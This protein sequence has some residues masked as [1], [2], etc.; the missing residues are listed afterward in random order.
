[1]QACAWPLSCAT[2]NMKGC[3]CDAVVARTIEA[4][5]LPHHL[6]AASCLHGHAAKGCQQIACKQRTAVVSLAEAALDSHRQVDSPFPLL[7][8]GPSH[9]R[10]AIIIAGQFLVIMRAATIAAGGMVVSS[11]VL[12][13]GIASLPIILKSQRSELGFLSEKEVGAC[14]HHA[15]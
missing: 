14:P 8:S 13:A 3:D 6:K 2:E 1:M 7:H 11:I 15:P 9:G 12:T 5:A 4:L 10:P